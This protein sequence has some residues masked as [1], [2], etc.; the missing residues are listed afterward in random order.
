MENSRGL[1][2][3]FMLFDENENGEGERKNYRCPH[4]SW[5]KIYYR[6]FRHSGNRGQWTSI[7]YDYDNDG[8]IDE[9][10]EM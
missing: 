5:A 7:G 9:W 10:A 2:P 4:K 8:D 6:L 3:V 1:V